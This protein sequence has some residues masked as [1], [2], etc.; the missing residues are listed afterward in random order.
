VTPDDQSQSPRP[1]KIDAA[2]AER[3]RLVR[4]ARQREVYGPN[5]RRRRRQ[6]ALRIERGEEILC[7]RCGLPIGPDQFWDLG[8]DD[9]NPS[10][11]RP[12]HRACNRAAP[13]RLPTSREW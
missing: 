2:L 1:S 12:E 3:R 10:L 4:N 11:E 8:H 5:H 7:P 6:Y 13:N 9:V